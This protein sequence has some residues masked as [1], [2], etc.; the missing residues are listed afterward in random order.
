MTV[1]VLFTEPPCTGATLPG[2]VEEGPLDRSEAQTLAEAMVKDTAA[3]VAASGGELVVLPRLSHVRLERSPAPSCVASS[4]TRSGTPNPFG[5]SH[6]SV[7]RHP[8]GSRTPLGT[9]SKRTTS[10]RSP[11]STAGRRRSTGRISTELE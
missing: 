10:P 2:L 6:S 1:H 5:S 7:T 4:T 11:C 3:A 9:C 8:R